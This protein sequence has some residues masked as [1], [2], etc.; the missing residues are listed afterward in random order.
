VDDTAA[1]ATLLE[2]ERV[3]PE[4]IH[5]HVVV[6]ELLRELLKRECRS[7][8]PGLRSIAQRVGSSRILGRSAK[9]YAQ[10]NVTDRRPC[11]ELKGVHL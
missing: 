11:K 4:E 9:D 5:Y 2:A 10:R 6:R 7:A 8:T 1:V 3:A